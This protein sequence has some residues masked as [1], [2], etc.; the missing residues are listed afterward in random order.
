MKKFFGAIAVIAALLM[1]G[2]AWGASLQSE[3]DI[4]AVQKGG[5]SVIDTDVPGE[6]SGAFVVGKEWLA[7]LSPGAAVKVDLGSALSRACGPKIDRSNIVYQPACDIGPTT[8]I[9][10]TIK[11][12]E[13]QQ[14]QGYALY[15]CSK[16]KAVAQLI[17]ATYNGL[18]L[19]GYNTMK[20]E[21]DFSIVDYP[22]G[23]IPAN[24]P[25]V[26]VPNGTAPNSTNRPTLLFSN[27]SGLAV[28]SP[29]TIAVTFA[30]KDGTAIDCPKT[31][32]ENLVV[33]W[34]DPQV[35][36]QVQHRQKGDEKDVS[37][38]SDSCGVPGYATSTIDVF[39]NPSRAKFKWE[40]FGS[41]TPTTTSSLAQIV[42]TDLGQIGPVNQGFCLDSN[43]KF[44]LTL[45]G[46]QAA[47]I[48]DT[49]DAKYAGVQLAGN[50]LFL[51]HS[52]PTWSI[53]SDFG[54]IDLRSC[55]TDGLL[56]TVNGKTAMQTAVYPVSLTYTAVK[57][58]YTLLDNV[59]A[60][61]WDVNAIKARVPYIPIGQGG[62]FTSFVSIGNRAA[63]AAEVW[64]E[65]VVS[66]AANTVNMPVSGKLAGPSAL[67]PLIPA[68]GVS[69]FNNVDLQQALGLAASIWKADLTFYIAVDK[70]MADV[71]AQMVNGPSGRTLLH[72][73]YNTGN[74]LDLWR[75]WQ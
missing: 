32:P 57:I 46:N 33:V 49:P 48:Q 19:G 37:F 5:C 39:A 15:D 7:E 73:L 11:N 68:T 44:N 54:A 21:F 25:L 51:T 4:A 75:N 9:E 41:D 71:S 26:M 45:F 58:T 28:G 64:L 69:N 8:I 61:V 42:V 40:G 20:F 10:F 1:A 38:S 6:P 43:V 27:T 34:A 2:G 65:G 29:M 59:T 60:F 23:T 53:A 14:N 35:T 70:D 56:I 55:R 12:G 17:D 24:T 47:I 22:Q 67:K 13:I 30:T 36:A 66:D 52:V 74:P 72:V 18:G 63:Y 3:V 50:N 62:T 31:G 16:G